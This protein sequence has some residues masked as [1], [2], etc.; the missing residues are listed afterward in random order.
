MLKEALLFTIHR[1]L[2]LLAKTMTRIGRME[3]Y[4]HY[5]L[6]I[7]AKSDELMDNKHE[8]GLS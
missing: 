3:L 7:N 2:S 5:L 1:Y 8:L 4:L 6:G